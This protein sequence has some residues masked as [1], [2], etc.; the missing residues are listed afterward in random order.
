MKNEKTEN[1]NTQNLMENKNILWN[2]G[3]TLKIYFMS[4]NNLKNK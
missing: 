2:N 3:S 4:N 1:V